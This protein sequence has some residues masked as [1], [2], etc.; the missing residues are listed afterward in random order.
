VGAW[1]FITP[2]LSVRDVEAAQ[3]YYRDHLGFKIAW[4]SED[5]SFGAVYNGTTE[6]FFARSEQSHPSSVC[7]VRV[8]DVEAVY[9]ACR[10][11]GAKI[12]SEL[13]TKVWSMR[14]F[15]VQ[16]PDGHVFRIGQST[17]GQATPDGP[18]ESDSIIPGGR[19]VA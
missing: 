16:D 17:L 3:R 18:V 19:R 4:R 15:S 11:A 1:R 14:E 6:I 5:G 7:C 10:A 9:A 2:Q 13:E 8:D 12:V